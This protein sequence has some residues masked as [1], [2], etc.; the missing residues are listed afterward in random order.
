LSQAFSVHQRDEVCRDL[1]SR[2]VRLF[3]RSVWLT[4]VPGRPTSLG[5]VRPCPA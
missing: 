1:A 5:L 3:Y 2:V 4:G